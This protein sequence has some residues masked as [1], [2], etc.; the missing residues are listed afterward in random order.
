M[1]VFFRKLH[2]RWTAALALEFFPH[3]LAFFLPVG[4]HVCHL[5]LF[6]RLSVW[7]RAGAR[8][9]PSTTRVIERHDPRDVPWQSERVVFQVNVNPDD[10]LCIDKFGDGVVSKPIDKSDQFIRAHLVHDAETAKFR[11]M[12]L[13]R[14]FVFL[15]FVGGGFGGGFG[16]CGFH[17][18]RS[19]STVWG[20]GEIPADQ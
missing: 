13:A 17:F 14:G 8:Q 9:R 18:S 5:Q 7:R 19:A 4:R 10:V 1:R 16:G 6:D 12:F 11:V 15:P 20:L 2:L 3:F